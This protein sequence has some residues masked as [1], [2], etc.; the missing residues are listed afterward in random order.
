MSLT[1]RI[2]IFAW[3]RPFTRKCRRSGDAISDFAVRGMPDMTVRVIPPAASHR[4]GRRSDPLRVELWLFANPAGRS[5]K[6]AV[7][8]DDVFHVW[9]V[10]RCRAAATSRFWRNQ[11]HL[12][13]QPNSRAGDAH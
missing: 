10:A 2:E 12:G 6:L 7:P 3:N 11:T 4:D 13:W 1:S 8:A 9:N 5:A